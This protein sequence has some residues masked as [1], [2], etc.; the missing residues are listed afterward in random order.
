MAETGN[1]PGEGRNQ[2]ISS[3]ELKKSRQNFQKLFENPPPR[4]NL[5]SASVDNYTH[6]QKEKTRNLMRIQK[7]KVNKCIKSVIKTRCFSQE[8]T[9]KKSNLISQPKIY[10]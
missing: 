8:T 9:T 6:Q 5:R 4:E 3:V 7:F 2:K 1:K 10:N